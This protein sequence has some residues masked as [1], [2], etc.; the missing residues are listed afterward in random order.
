M[1]TA[2]EARNNLVSVDKILENYLTNIVEKQIR[3]ASADNTETSFRIFE[4]EKDKDKWAFEV[5]P[6]IKKV[7][8]EPFDGEKFTNAVI[9]VLQDNG[10][11]VERK[12]FPKR[13]ESSMKYGKLVVSWEDA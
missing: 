5:L 9:S 6:S 1:I 3:E 8:D 7:G 2:K 10:Y 12:E 11:K 4:I 13:H